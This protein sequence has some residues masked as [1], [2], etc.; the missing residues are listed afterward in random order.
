MIAQHPLYWI[1]DHMEP[2]TWTRPDF[3]EVNLG[4]EINSY[5]PSEI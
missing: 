5:A 2:K 1:E 4:C 3:D